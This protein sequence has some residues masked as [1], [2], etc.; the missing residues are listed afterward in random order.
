[1]RKTTVFSTVLILT[2]GVAGTVSADDE[3]SILE[4]VK[5][6][7]MAADELAAVKGL[8]VHLITPSQ[9]TQN[10]GVPGLQ[11]AGDVKTENNWSNDW[12]GSDGEPVAPSYHGLCV[13]T[14]LSGPG[15]SVAFIPGGA[16]QCPL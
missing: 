12:G 5:A 16:T 8:H 14:G 2:M 4:G 9:N 7:P 6:V 1:M 11:L 13:S 3:F 15:N 10:F